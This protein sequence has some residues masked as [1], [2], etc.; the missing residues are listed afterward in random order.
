MPYSLL[1]LV[2]IVLALTGITADARG[3][4]FFNQV[5]SEFLASDDATK[6]EIQR[7]QSLAP[8]KSAALNQ[9]ALGQARDNADAYAAFPNQ[10]SQ[11]EKIAPDAAKKRLSDALSQLPKLVKGCQRKPLTETLLVVKRQLSQFQIGDPFFSQDSELSEAEEA[12]FAEVGQFLELAPEKVCERYPDQAA[13]DPMISQINAAFAIGSN[14]LA[15]QIATLREQSPRAKNLAQ[16][17]EKYRDSLLKTIEDQSAPVNKVADQLGWIIGVFCVFGI[18]M[19]VSLKVFTADVQL[20]LVASGQ[21]IQFAT[22]MVLLIVI[23]VLGMSKLLTENTLG[24]LLGG[25]GG[26][27]LS[28]GIGRAASRATSRE[29]QN[30]PH[31][32]AGG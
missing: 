32:P 9:E 17:W 8:S 31:P 27:V 20:E 14:R 19:F 24:T 3:L 22:V 2:M 5:D 25:I 1:S 29:I 23:C 13:F 21:V 15:K 18:L 16:A 11:L 30:Q 26:Y 6:K 10:L 4:P 12:T 7:I 28:Q